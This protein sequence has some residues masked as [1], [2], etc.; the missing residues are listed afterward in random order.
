[1][2]TTPIIEPNDPTDGSA[3]PPASSAVHRLLVIRLGALGDVVRTLPAASSV[4]DHYPDARLSWLVEPASAGAL[5]GRSWID[6]VL[7]F[8]RPT[9]SGALAEG[10]L[11][12]AAATVRSLVAELRQRRFDLV[13]DFHS[14]LKSGVLSWLT[15][16]RRRVALAPPLGREGSWIFAHRRVALGAKPRSRFDRNRRLVRGMGIHTDERE[17]PLDLDAGAQ[18]DA[19]AALAGAGLG[20]D[21]A[22]IAMH[23]GSS[24]ST[25]HKRWSAEGY[26]SLAR[27]LR[28]RRGLSS[29]V[30]AGPD[31][32]EA[33]LADAVVAAS[34]GAAR[35]A[36]TTA[37]FDGL[38]A[39]LARASLLVGSDSGPLHVASL[40][41]TPVVQILGPTHP[42][43]NRP[44]A[45]TP[46]RQ[47]RSG[48]ACSP[49]RRGCAP[50]HCLRVLAPDSVREAALDLLD[51][52]AAGGR[53]RSRARLAG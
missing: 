33:A 28:R 3:W 20:E 37:G 16:S 39:L 42:V 51:E 36:P 6:E 26:G 31:P 24:R 9:L 27:A 40:V 19:H 17:D 1:M 38:A 5:R 12:R 2:A 46:F 13:I 49:C 18:R 52:C 50:A 8:P 21:E 29:L 32:E 11:D 53:R 43:E 47:V 10:R 22:W 48:V 7:E 45:A 41:R 34:D 35:R 15:G 14:I 4:R 30:L 23:P 44:W 25:P